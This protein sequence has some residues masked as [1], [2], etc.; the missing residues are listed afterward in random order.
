MSL[1]DVLAKDNEVRKANIEQVKT[2]L[3]LDLR[4]LELALN[5]STTTFLKDQL[6]DEG[7][8]S[9]LVM[10]FFHLNNNAALE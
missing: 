10:R 6:Q 3:N 5:E 7:G 1:E 8:L 2:T 4:L 9:E